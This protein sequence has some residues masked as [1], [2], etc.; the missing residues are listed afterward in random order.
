MDIKKII[1][2]DHK[3][4]ETRCKNCEKDE[5]NGSNARTFI[6]WLGRMRPLFLPSAED[7]MPRLQDPGARHN[8]SVNHS[9]NI[10]FVAHMH[11]QFRTEHIHQK[12]RGTHSN[13]RSGGSSA[14]TLAKK[15]RCAL[16]SQFP[17]R[18]PGMTRSSKSPG[19][20][21]NTTRHPLFLRCAGLQPHLHV[22][23]VL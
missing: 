11:S 6:C 23:V 12:N 17:P 4:R 7:E 2:R 16:A 1:L 3:K 15:I 22:L 19:D 8:E 20:R 21:S 9:N 18:C 14:D 13:R 5:A 10:S